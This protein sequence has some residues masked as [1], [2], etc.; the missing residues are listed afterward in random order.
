MQL[1]YLDV[2]SP[3]PLQDFSLT[4]G[5]RKNK[6]TELDDRRLTLWHEKVG[7]QKH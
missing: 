5:A 7:R 1:N 6:R 3:H 4:S 2:Y